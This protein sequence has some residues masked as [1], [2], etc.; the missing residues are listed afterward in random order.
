VET[1]AALLVVFVVFVVFLVGPA[2]AQLPSSL[3]VNGEGVCPNAAAVA[4]VLARL[5]PDLSLAADGPVAEVRDLGGAYEVRA[6]GESRRLDDPRRR[7]G[8]RA[9][10]AALAITLLLD[11]PVGPP[12][13][14]T[15]K[16]EEERPLP[17][18][19]IPSL[20]AP[21]PTRALAEPA[22]VTQA[23]P[24]RSRRPSRIELELAGVVDGAPAIASSVDLVTGGGSLR[25]AVGGRYVAAV[26]GVSG[27]APASARPAS[28]EVTVA[29]VPF[30]VGLRLVAPLGRVDLGGDLGLGLA[31]LRIEAK[32]LVA[33]EASTR[34][35]VGARAA[36]WLRVWLTSRVALQLAGQ[37]AVSFA[38]YDLVV[39]PADRIATTPWLW[40]GGALG[41]VARF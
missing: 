39:Q 6:G 9:A 22:R 16:V 34:L 5:H 21:Q 29:R 32:N 25:L 7:C 19:T 30:D 38:P 20:V 37:L 35:D 41:I 8:E 28:V 40:A 36:L 4:Q 2:G 11:P 23:V 27:L 15:P 17:S 3:W 1:R 12:D 10:A 18:R 14:P 13:E 33:A 24:S 31:I 26:A